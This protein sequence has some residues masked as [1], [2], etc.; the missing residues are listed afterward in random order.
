V[1]LSGSYP[2]AVPGRAF[3]YDFQAD[4]RPPGSTL[5]YRIFTFDDWLF[6]V[7]NNSVACGA[8]TGGSNTTTAT[9]DGNGDGRMDYLA[10]ADYAKYFGKYMG[11]L[12][13]VVGTVLE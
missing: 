1:E 11:W 13:G 9:A 4:M 5:A 8:A 7:V 12:P 6:P 10:D 3:F 2:D